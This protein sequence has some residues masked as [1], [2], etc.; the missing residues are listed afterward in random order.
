MHRKGGDQAYHEADFGQACDPDAPAH[1]QRTDQCKKGEELNSRTN[2]WKRGGATHIRTKNITANR[3]RRS[4]RLLGIGASPDGAV[5]CRFAG[6]GSANIAL[7]GSILL[8]RSQSLA[9]P[10]LL[11]STQAYASAPLL[12]R[13]GGQT[14][15]SSP[16]RRGGD[17]EMSGSNRCQCESAWMPSV[18]AV[19]AV[20]LSPAIRPPDISG[21]LRCLL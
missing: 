1:S 21:I 2:E 10:G 6:G 4:I 14:R 19:A 7:G 20:R 11:W 13:G 3:V 16:P 18:P 5:F 8:S 12:Y 17:E 15:G 9:P